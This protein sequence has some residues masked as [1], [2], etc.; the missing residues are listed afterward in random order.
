MVEGL[1]PSGVGVWPSPAALGLCLRHHLGLGLTG[2]SPAASTLLVVALQQ[3]AAVAV[4]GQQLPAAMGMRLRV[5]T[6]A[7]GVAVGDWVLRGSGAAAAVAAL[8]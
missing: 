7:V 3:P 8:C 6:A 4:A 5:L 2:R 1:P